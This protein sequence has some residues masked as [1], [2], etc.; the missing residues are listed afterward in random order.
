MKTKFLII[1]PILLFA[2]LSF[3]F[4]CVDE[5]VA[6]PFEHTFE[7][8]VDIYPLKKVYSLTDTI[9]LT[10]DVPTQYLFDTKTNS[11]VLVD[12][13]MISISAGYNEFG[14]YIT[15]PPN[16]FADVITAGGVNLDRFNSQWGTTGYAESYGCGRPDYTCRIGFK[17][18]QK[19]VYSLM[20]PTDQFLESCPAKRVPYYASITYRYK[21]VDL[22]LDVF[23]SLSKNDKGGNDGINFYNGKIRDRL[24]FV[25]SVQ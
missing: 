22:G 16:G 12:S 23:N 7:I 18:L 9:W 4:R 8:P 17:P 6:K 15:N 2:L 3:N 14:T 21:N 1:L 11:N 13:G 19:G 5:A 20:L 25:F 10:T 24:V